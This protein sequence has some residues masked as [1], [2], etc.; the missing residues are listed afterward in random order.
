M[1]PK[2]LGTSPVGLIS[3]LPRRNSSTSSVVDVTTQDDD[4]DEDS[5]VS[6]V[7]DYFSSSPSD[8]PSDD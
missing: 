4:S 3:S 5:S 1:I 2:T 8:S 7:S 6:D